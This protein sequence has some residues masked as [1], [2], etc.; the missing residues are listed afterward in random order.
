MPKF[1]WRLAIA[2]VS[3]AATVV[4]TLPLSGSRHQARPWIGGHP[5]VADIIWPNDI[6]DDIIWPNLVMAED[7]TQGSDGDPNSN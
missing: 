2:V 5:V 1:R 3:F 6:V 4:L 7:G